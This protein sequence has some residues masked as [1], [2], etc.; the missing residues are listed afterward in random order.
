MQ[1][2]EKIFEYFP[3]KLKFYLIFMEIIEIFFVKLIYVVDFKCLFAW[4]F[5]NF[6]ARRELGHS[7]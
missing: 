3:W 2:H 1:F 5:L 6:V 7:S 4:N